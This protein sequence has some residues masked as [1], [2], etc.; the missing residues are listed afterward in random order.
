[1][2]LFFVSLFPIGLFRRSFVLVLLAWAGL[3]WTLNNNST[4]PRLMRY[5][6][7][8]REMAD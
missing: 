6:N 3:L 1:M 4:T 8:V 7:G 5:P 2:A